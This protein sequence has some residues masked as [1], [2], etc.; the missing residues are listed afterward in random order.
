MHIWLP[1]GYRLYL[2]IRWSKANL[3]DLV[4]AG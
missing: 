4:Q 3:L 1:Q 2:F